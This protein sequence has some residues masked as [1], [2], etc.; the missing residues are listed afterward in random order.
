MKIKKILDCCKTPFLVKNLKSIN[1][2]GITFNSKN[3]K[4][5]FIF[6]A[7]KGMK[8][9]GEDF[10]NDVSNIE[11]VIILTSLN[12]SNIGNKETMFVQ[13]KSVRELMG[14]ISSILYP[15]S[16]N[17]KIAITGT[18]GKTSIA[19]YVSELSSKQ[20]ISNAIFGTFGVLFKKKTF[21]ETNLTTPDI[22]T[23]HKILSELN[24]KKCD[25]VIFEASSIGLHQKRLHNIY[26]DKL[27]F[28]NLTN[29]HLDY[30]KD[31][32]NY[33]MSKLILFNDNIKQTS[34]A[35]INADDKYSKF[36]IKICK[37][38]KIR[39]LDYGKNAK[40]L[41]IIKIIKKT[42]TI[43]THL[44]LNHKIFCINFPCYASY[45]VYNQIC[46]FLLVF[47][48]KLNKKKIIDNLNMSDP[49]GR[50]EKIYDK[51]KIR[52]FIDYAHTPDALKQVLSTLSNGDGNL[53]I[54][55][56]CGGDRDIQK[57][58]LMSKEAIK[59]CDYIFMTSDN[60]RTESPNKIFSDMTKTLKKN[61]L[62]KIEIIENRSKAI[63][64]AIDFIKSGD[65]LIIAGKGHEKY[66]IIDNKRIYFSDSEIATNKLLDK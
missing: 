52:V 22:I 63:C 40:H 32:K 28:T 11:N 58:P 45:Q 13:T 50:L 2:K 30:H 15:N 19:H 8:T 23:N 38:N 20:S 10:I 56:G 55:F 6:V 62:K 49:N 7:I 59:Y 21:A 4:S 51:N 31:F 18:N 14:E 60:P 12:V 43:E 27:A 41:K 9:N 37:K 16:I 17:D 39:I 61:D 42:D 35:V 47:G 34:I 36:F 65:T 66:Q 25:R 26:F 46:A 1:V 54:V 44:Q 29:D 24:K 64:A 5:N 33:R 3:I 57:R 48:K 53:V